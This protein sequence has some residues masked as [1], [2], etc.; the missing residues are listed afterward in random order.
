[1]AARDCEERAILAPQ[2]NSIVYVEISA[3][4]NTRILVKDIYTSEFKMIMW[5]MCAYFVLF[6]ICYR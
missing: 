5:K 1:M 2:G 6:S 4:I 3:K